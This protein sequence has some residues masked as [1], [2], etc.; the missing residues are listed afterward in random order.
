MAALEVLLH[1]HEALLL[2]NAAKLRRAL[3]ALRSPALME[4]A[5]AKERADAAALAQAQQALRAR[6][7]KTPAD[8]A[9]ADACDAD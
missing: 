4:R 9:V 3:E 6:D 5:E 1:Q 8:A 2:A 7:Q